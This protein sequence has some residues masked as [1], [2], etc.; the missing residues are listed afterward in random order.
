[1]RRF[2]HLNAEQ[3]ARIMSHLPTAAAAQ[4]LTLDMGQGGLSASGEPGSW[5]KPRPPTPGRVAS[6]V[7]DMSAG[8]EAG[9]HGLRHA[10][11][12]IIGDG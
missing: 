2:F 5:V 1:M 7:M 3:F 12:C 4:T 8:P 6:C 10:A 11:G 9:D